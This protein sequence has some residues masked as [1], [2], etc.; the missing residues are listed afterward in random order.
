VIKSGTSSFTMGIPGSS[1]TQ[2]RPAKQKI[3]N[4]MVAFWTWLR[5]RYG[6]SKYRRTSRLHAPAER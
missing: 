2:L 5:T 3:S 1:N 6:V 4:S